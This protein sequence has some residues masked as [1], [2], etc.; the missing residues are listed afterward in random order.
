MNPNINI[1]DMIQEMDVFDD[2]HKAFLNIRTGEFVTLSDEDMSA[3]EEGEPLE[4]YPDWQ[5]DVIQ[6]AKDVLFTDDYLELPSKYDIH[7]YEIMKRF[8][9]TVEDDE[10]H[11]SLLHAISGRGAFRIF[12]DTIY[13]HGIA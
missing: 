3:A 10:L 12:K 1:R 7:E 4:D 8:C 2:N 11:D 5:Q 6:E 13:E 9:Y